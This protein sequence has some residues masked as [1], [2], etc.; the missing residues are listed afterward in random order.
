[1]AATR[2]ALAVLSR[3]VKVIEGQ[4]RVLSEDGKVQQP[5]KRRGLHPWARYILTRPLFW[6]YAAMITVIGLT[7]GL[8]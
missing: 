6:I 5:P 7:E 3:G 1:M 4:F 8:W 2:A